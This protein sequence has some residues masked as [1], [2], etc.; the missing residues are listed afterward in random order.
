MDTYLAYARSR[1][2]TDEHRFWSTLPIDA[3]RRAQ[4]IR[5]SRAGHSD[6]VV[7]L[8]LPLIMLSQLVKKCKGTL[9]CRLVD[10][11]TL[12]IVQA[13][14]EEYGLSCLPV[15]WT[16]HGRFSMGGRSFIDTVGWLSDFHPILF[17]LR[18]KGEREIIQSFRDFYTT[19]PN[20]GSSFRWVSRFGPQTDHAELE[21]RLQTPFAINYRKSK[22]SNLRGFGAMNSTDC[23]KPMLNVQS[24]KQTSALP[25][26]LTFT[27]DLNSELKISSRIIGAVSAAESERLMRSVYDKFLYFTQTPR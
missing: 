20:F 27:V 14:A 5:L 7:D 1:A 6:H 16:G 21:I 22:G 19:I 12:I 15:S 17:S 23:S 4:E 3:F 10:I 2:G 25:F 8:Y 9:A 18:A 11:V 24:T 26:T 13:T